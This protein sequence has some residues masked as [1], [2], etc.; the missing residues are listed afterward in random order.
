[1]Q[2]LTPKDDAGILHFNTQSKQKT[3]DT[4]ID[5]PKENYII[6]KPVFFAAC[7]K[8]PACVASENTAIIQATCPNVTIVEFDTD[9]WVLAAEPHKVNEEILKWLESLKL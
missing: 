5:I 7:L 2:K 8:D 3:A 6:S 4:E 9:H 1:M